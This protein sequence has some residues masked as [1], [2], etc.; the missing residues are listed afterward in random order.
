MLEFSNNYL[1]SISL[2]HPI[3]RVDESIKK[4]SS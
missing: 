1:W 4:N 3:L 2:S